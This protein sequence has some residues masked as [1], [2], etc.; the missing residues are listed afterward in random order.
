MNLY[1]KAK[2]STA[3]SLPGTIL[4]ERL[5]LIARIYLNENIERKNTSPTLR[6]RKHEKK[7]SLMQTTSKQYQKVTEKTGEKSNLRQMR[8]MTQS[9]H[10]G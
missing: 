2:E 6:I 1:L 9:K 7:V 3:C 10:I 4:E 5:I 8:N